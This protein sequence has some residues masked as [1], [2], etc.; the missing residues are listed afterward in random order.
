MR[1]CH[2]CSSAWVRYSVL[3]IVDVIPNGALLQIS[4][5]PILARVVGG[6]FRRCRAYGQAH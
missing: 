5:P 2:S 3:R 4:D 1:G 6:V